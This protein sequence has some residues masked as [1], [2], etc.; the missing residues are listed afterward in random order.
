[1]LLARNGCRVLAA[2]PRAIP[3]RY[4][5]DALPVASRNGTCWINYRRPVG[6][7]ST[8]SPPTTALSASAAGRALLTARAS[9]TARA[10]R[11]ST[12]CWSRRRERREPRFGKPRRFASSFGRTI[13]CRRAPTGQ[14]REVPRRKSHDCRGCRRPPPIAPPRRPGGGSPPPD[15]A[16]PCFGRA[17]RRSNRT[18]SARPSALPRSSASTHRRHGRCERRDAARRAAGNGGLRAMPSPRAGRRSIGTAAPNPAIRPTRRLA[19]RRRSL[20]RYRIPL[21]PLAEQPRGGGRR[22]IRASLAANDTSSV[23]NLSFGQTVG[24]T[25]GQLPLLD[26]GVIWTTALYFHL[27]HRL[28][29]RIRAYRAQWRSLWL[30]SGA[31][32]SPQLLHRLSLVTRDGGTARLRRHTDNRPCV[33]PIGGLRARECCAQRPCPAAIP[34][35]TT[36]TP[37]IVGTCLFSPWAL[38]A[39]SNAMMSISPSVLTECSLGPLHGSVMRRCARFRERRPLTST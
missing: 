34:P 16:T 38:H 15:S 13:G 36:G 24:G 26:R 25:G 35:P 31:L 7:L 33:A 11:S 20:C 37:S 27:L 6:L 18:A 39:A 19:L 23:A 1:M 5:L 14:R 12:F 10:G 8:A 2:D 17:I 22:Q 32:L 29:S 30:G 4:D 3:K 21:S 28:A 9:C